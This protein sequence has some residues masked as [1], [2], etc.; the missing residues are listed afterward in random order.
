MDLKQFYTYTNTQ[1]TENE[2]VVTI[3]FDKEHPIYKGHS[4]NNP[5]VPGIMQIE[6][7]TDILKNKIVFLS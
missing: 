1:T 3:N 4:P 6:I 2:V 7:I 5:V